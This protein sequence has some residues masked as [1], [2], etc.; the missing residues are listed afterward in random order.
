MYLNGIEK[1]MTMWRIAMTKEFRALPASVLWRMRGLLGSE[2][3]TRINGQVMIN[4]FLPPFPS[5]AF[6]GL[7]RSIQ[8]LLQHK[9]IPISAYVSVTDKCRYHC[10]HCSKTK[11]GGHEM[12]SDTVVKVVSDLQ[13][14]GVCIIGFTGGEPLLSDDLVRFVKA[15]DQRSVSLLFTSGDGLTAEKVRELKAAGLFGVAVSVDHFERRIHDERRGV[16]GAFDSAL[17]AVQLVRD[18]GLYTMIQLVATKEMAQAGM[19]QK[20]LELAGELGV[21]EIR[22]LEPMP[23]GQLMKCSGKCILDCRERKE[24]QQLHVRTNRSSSLP[25]VS[26]FA[27]IESGEFYGCGAGFQH[28]YVDAMG[29]VCPC[30]FTPISFGNVH[31]EDI[32]TIWE[33]M[34]DAFR[35]PRRACFLLENREKLNNEFTGELPLAYGEVRDKTIFSD[36]AGLPEYY[37]ILGWT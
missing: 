21:H 10:W 11:R 20:Y 3:F 34:N 37:K 25:K 18:N 13:K 15:V 31:E 2:K 9:A 14:M 33:R 17:K 5:E 16:D 8:A 30:D 35:R 32:S 22:L 7:G 6:N 24:L 26:S 19:F 1:D 23:T 12:S 28:L 29:N 4:S 36:G 27:H